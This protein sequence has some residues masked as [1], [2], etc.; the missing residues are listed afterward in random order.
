MRVMRRPVVTLSATAEMKPES[1]CRR[2][3]EG[4]YVLAM[5]TAVLG[6]GAKRIT[7][8][9]AAAKREYRRP[10]AQPVVRRARTSDIA[11][12]DAHRN[13][14]PSFVLVVAEGGAGS[15]PGRT[16][17]ER[18]ERARESAAGFRVSL[19]ASVGRS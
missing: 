4:L 10:L 9:S 1:E 3:P 2:A 11:A 18:A 7:Y 13:S 19:E 15:G 12:P 5:P 14:G 16:S 6:R 8:E 17:G